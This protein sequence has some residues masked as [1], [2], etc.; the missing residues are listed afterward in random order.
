MKS[1]ALDTFLEYPSLCTLI[2]KTL[3]IFRL[4]EQH[5]C[6]CLLQLWLTPKVRNRIDGLMVHSLNVVDRGSSPDIMCYF[7]AKHAALGRKSKYLL[8]RN[9]DNVSEWGGM[10]IR[11]LLFQ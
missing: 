1:S 8:A 11:G 9:Q 7:S 3:T 10:S 2:I 4:P 5:Y 6:T